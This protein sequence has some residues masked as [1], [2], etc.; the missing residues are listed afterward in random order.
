MRRP[1][2]F[3][4]YRRRVPLI[5]LERL[6]YAD[7]IPM[8]YLETYVPYERFSALYHV[9]FTVNSLYE[10]LDRLYGLSIYQGAEKF[11]KRYCRQPERRTSWGSKDTADLFCDDDC[12]DRS[13]R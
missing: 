3:S 7:D 5:Y 12:H 1:R 13:E 2:R 8:V 10:S 11:L 9:D 4:V 6:R